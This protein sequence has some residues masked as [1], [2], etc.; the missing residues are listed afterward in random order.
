MVTVSGFITF[1][2]KVTHD[3]ML[4]YTNS[5]VK[6]IKIMN[7]FTNIITTILESTNKAQRYYHVISTSNLDNALSEGLKGNGKIYVWGSYRYA[8]QFKD[9]HEDPN[10]SDEPTPMSMLAVELPKGYNVEILPDPETSE[11]GDY[12]P[13]FQESY[14]IMTDH[15]PADLLREF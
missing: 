10:Y 6:L 5:G 1:K 11:G 14:M 12:Y 15:I 9:M 3:I 2:T 13:E 8:E 4:S 7:R